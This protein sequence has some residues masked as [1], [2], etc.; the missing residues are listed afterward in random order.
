M[1]IAYITPEYPH[2]ELGNSGGMG[3]SI[4]NLVTAL[5]KMGHKISLFV[6]DQ[7]KTDTFIEDGVTFHLIAK[8]HYKIGGFYFYR[9][10]IE[11]YID[12]HS[13][14]VDIIEAP[15]W[16]GITAFM[17]LK[18]PLVIRFHGSDTYFCHIEGRPQKWKNAF[19]EKRAVRKAKAFIAPTQFAG[20]K[21]IQLFK[22]PLS[23]LKII[24]YGL[25]LDKFN[26]NSP[27]EFISKRLLNIGTLIRKKGVFQLIEMFNKI[28]IAH[29]TAKLHFIGAD[30][31][32]VQT[33]SASTWQLMQEIMSP[34]AIEAITYLGKVPYGQVKEEIQKAHICV[35]PSLAETLGMVTIESMALQKVVINTS[36]GWA[37]DLIEHGKDG[38]MHHPDDI[39]AYVNT[40]TTVFENDALR[41]RIIKAARETIEEQF[42]INYVAQ[43]NVS[44]YNSLI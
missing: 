7:H 30:S 17:S 22:Q 16:T 11:Q 8:K 13:S 26:N 3:T 9:K 24:H 41:K 31:Y 5:C 29:P 36:I 6:Y 44:F 15:D 20:K 2:P 34:A 39:D 42:D 18:K 25:E 23:K 35:F 28:I 43:S 37:Q 19:F 12:K 14:D 33:G 32:D 21:S 1:H 10:H 40:V 4:K 27:E 38:F